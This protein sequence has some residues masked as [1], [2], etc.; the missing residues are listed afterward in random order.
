MID[1]SILQPGD[2]LL[3]RVTPNSPWH[4]KVIAWGEQL[5]KKKFTKFN[6]C[7]VA[8]VDYDTDLILEAV[9]PWTHLTLFPGKGNNPV[10]VY[11]V[12]DVT[13]EQVKL[14]ITWA[15]QNLGVWYDLGRLFFGLFPSR[16]K[17]IC[18][19]YIDYSWDNA[20]RSLGDGKL[21]SPDEIAVSSQIVLIAKG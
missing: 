1:T 11:R 12:K 2:I 4:D 13:P 14:A 17:V 7:H 18:S 15:H 6:Y 9:W 16:H 19:T 8:M 10:E 21:L 20:G 3:Y 5:L